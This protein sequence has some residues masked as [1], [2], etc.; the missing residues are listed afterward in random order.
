MV[1][2]VFIVDHHQADGVVCCRFGHDLP[3]RDGV[4]PVLQVVRAYVRLVEL[5]VDDYRELVEREEV[6]RL[7]V[8]VFLE[9]N[10]IIAIEVGSGAL[11]EEEIPTAVEHDEVAEPVFLEIFE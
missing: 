1:Q 9:V 4:Q 8:E 2:L 6:F 5:E 11:A 7:F 10:D 3:R